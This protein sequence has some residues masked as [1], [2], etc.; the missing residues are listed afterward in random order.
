MS[1]LNAADFQI[2]D[3]DA[4]SNL[5]R[6]VGTCAQPVTDWGVLWSRRSHLGGA[7]GACRFAAATGASAIAGPRG[8][9][10]TPASGN[11]SAPDIPVGSDV[12]MD[13]R[14][15]SASDD[16]DIS[17]LLLRPLSLLRFPFSLL[18]FQVVSGRCSTIRT[19]D[20]EIPVYQCNT[21][22]AVCMQACATCMPCM[23]A[24]RHPQTLATAR[25]CY[26]D[27]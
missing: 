5:V 22:N 27:T 3:S 20:D 12:S 4:A 10:R 9:F 16:V 15:G 26:Y 11:H 24:W 7:A 14:D 19:S 25:P 17:T 21:E 13:A 23:R 6:S 18:R 1:A 2:D 8:D